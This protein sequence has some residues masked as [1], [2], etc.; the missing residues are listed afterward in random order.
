M[1][2]ETE[3]TGL[4]IYGEGFNARTV[5]VGI[6]LEAGPSTPKPTA[7]H[8][9]RWNS[10]STTETC[11]CTTQPTMCWRSNSATGT[12]LTGHESPWRKPAR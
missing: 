5:Q 6:G 10:G 1:A 3:T 8:G 4:E 2:V 7:P 12:R 11:N 9:E